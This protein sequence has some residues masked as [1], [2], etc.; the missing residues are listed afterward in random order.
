MKN[1]I[2][3]QSGKVLFSTE[4]AGN[5]LNVSDA[6]GHYFC[7]VEHDGSKLNVKDKNDNVIASSNPSK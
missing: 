2:K 4:Q 1:E 3:D 6:Q 5:R 7:C